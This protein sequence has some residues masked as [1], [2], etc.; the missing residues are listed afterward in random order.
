MSTPADADVE[1]ACGAGCD[2]VFDYKLSQV[3][4]V[5]GVGDAVAV[6]VAKTPQIGRHPDVPTNVVVNYGPQLLRLIEDKPSQATVDALN[7]LLTYWGATNWS[8]LDIFGRSNMFEYFKE[9]HINISLLL[10][11]RF[12]LLSIMRAKVCFMTNLPCARSSA[13]WIH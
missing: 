10:Q 9:N 3:V 12:G 2:F 6:V 4:A 5:A 7:D 8:Q 1:E 11:K 13:R